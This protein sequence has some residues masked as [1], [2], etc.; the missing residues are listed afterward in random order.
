MLREEVDIANIYSDV[1][2][3]VM[4]HLIKFVTNISTVTTEMKE[5]PVSVIQININYARTKLHLQSRKTFKNAHWKNR[6]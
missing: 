6:R 1:N 5:K 4:E 2:V 3:S